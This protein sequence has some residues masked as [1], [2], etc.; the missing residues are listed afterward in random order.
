MD[1]LRMHWQKL[2]KTQQF[3]QQEFF[4]AENRLYCE[5]SEFQFISA[6]VESDNGIVVP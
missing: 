6:K 1:D 3:M 4:F 5:I 2:R